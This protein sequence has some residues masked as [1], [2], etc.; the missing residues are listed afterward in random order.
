MFPGK[1]P[2]QMGPNKGSDE[3]KWPRAPGWEQWGQASVGKV[4]SSAGVGTVESRREE[5]AL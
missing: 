1:R 4:K 5:R 3:G 2:L